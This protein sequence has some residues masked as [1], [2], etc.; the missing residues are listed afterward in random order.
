MKKL[1]LFLYLILHTTM[2][3]SQDPQ[4]L[5]KTDFEGKVIEGSIEALI[6]EIEKGSPIRVGWQLD[7][8]GNKESD[9]EHW[10]DAEF[11]SVLNGHVFNQI[12]PIYRQIPKAEIPQVEIVASPMMWTAIIGT[13]GKLLSRYIIPDLDS[14]EP[15][16]KR[17]AL[18]KRTEVSE[19]MVATIWVKP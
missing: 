2:A 7:F 15:E 8:N 10:I 5:L 19:R 16:A 3:F 9:L 4:L 12:S 17:E 11:L 13:N 18:A 6:A 14:I 1:I